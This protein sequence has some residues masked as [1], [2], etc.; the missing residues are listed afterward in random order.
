MKLISHLLAGFIITDTPS[1]AR[2][3]SSQQ[4][5]KEKKYIYMY[6]YTHTGL[7]VRGYGGTPY[8]TSEKIS[9]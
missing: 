1:T 5:K 4:E 2:E 7:K 6:I 9:E 3:V 8:T